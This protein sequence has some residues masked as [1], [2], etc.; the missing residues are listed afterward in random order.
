MA[1]S[2]EI[3]PLTEALDMYGQPDSASAYSL[4]GHITISLSSPYSLFERRRTARM[5]LKSLILTFEGQS[6]VI[7]PSIGYSGVRLCSISQELAPGTSIEL[8]NEGHEE[9]ETPCQWNIVFNLPIPGWL[10]E[11][12]SYGGESVGNSYALYATAK[13]INLDDIGAAPWSFAAFCSPFRSRSKVADGMKH[14]TVRRF[15][16][17][18]AAERVTPPTTTYQVNAASKS[19][20]DGLSIPQDILSK[21]QVLA[22]VPEHIHPTDDSIPL[23]L[24]MRTQDLDASDCKRLQVTSFTVDVVQREK[25]RYMPSSTYRSRFPILPS[26]QQPPNIPLRNPHPFCAVYDIG[27]YLPD[28][29]DEYTSRS[30][31][32][33]PAEEPGQYMLNDNNY[34]FVNDTVPTSNPTWYTLEATIP[35][36]VDQIPDDKSADWAGRPRL[37]P[38]ISGPLVNVNHD[39]AVT[40]SITYDMPDGTTQAKEKLEF[41]VPVSFGRAAPLLGSQSTFA[42][43]P[44]LE[45]TQ[46]PSPLPL[47]HSEIPILPVYSQLYDASGNQKIDYSVPLPLYAPRESIPHSSAIEPSDNATSELS[48]NLQKDYISVEDDEERQPLLS[49][50]SS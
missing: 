32:L 1:V 34:V 2:L 24:R 25:Y 30:F 36:L 9:D 44:T 5:L 29:G 28:F 20:H 46:I 23:T 38:T 50:T 17:L 27:L 14:I 33:L 19:R 6:E 45:T 12:D 35:F 15:T 48:S 26:S 41:T 16:T 13:F 31:S 3:Y 49:S 8:N 47:L 11:S 10:P 43:L 21:I 37:H 18:P 7:T 4:S 39:L 42:T 40:V 22:S